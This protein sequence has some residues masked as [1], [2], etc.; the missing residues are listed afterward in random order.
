MLIRDARPDDAEAMSNIFLAA[1]RAGWSSFLPA[2][3]L[4]TLAA[5]PERWQRDISRQGGARVLIAEH[6]G[7]V[8]GFSILRP[9]ADTDADPHQTGELDLIYTHPDGW[10]LGA[11]RALLAAATLAL[12][13]AGFHDATLWTAE[14]NARPR[15]VYASAGW[16]LDGATRE[17]TFLG[18]AFTE[19][20]H[21]TKL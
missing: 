2:A 15:R 3:G 11:G 12:R 8:V 6:E 14:A 1:A 20:R 7:R 10:G 4:Q 9:S 19:L 18:V 16:E 5:P 21:R 13:E 17:K